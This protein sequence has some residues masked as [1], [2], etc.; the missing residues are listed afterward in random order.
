MTLND[1]Q[2]AAVGT[3]IYPGRHSALGLCY[4][5]LKLNGEAGEVAENIG[6][7]IRDDA[8]G[9]PK[10]IGGGGTVQTPLTPER[11]EKLLKELGDTLWY[12]AAAADEL[13]FTLESIAQENIDKLRD[14]K[15][16]GVLGG[17][18]DDR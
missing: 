10:E 12:I 9:Q 14:R 18:G 13:G 1:Y 5:G 6:K 11:R 7:A 15:E 17:S 8:F 3:A 16:R 2:H 4:T